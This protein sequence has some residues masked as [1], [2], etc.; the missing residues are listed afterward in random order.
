MLENP[1]KP[2]L[3]SPKKVISVIVLLRISILYVPAFFVHNHLSL[4]RVNLYL[5]RSSN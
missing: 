4:G 2:A 5:M 3:K 1:P